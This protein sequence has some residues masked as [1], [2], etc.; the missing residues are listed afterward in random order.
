ML[1]RAQILIFIVSYLLRYIFVILSGDGGSSQHLQEFARF[2]TRL[3]NLNQTR[4]EDRLSEARTRVVG[5]RA[6]EA[7]DTLLA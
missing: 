7:L 3:W 5:L 1:M 4:F 6:T 2:A